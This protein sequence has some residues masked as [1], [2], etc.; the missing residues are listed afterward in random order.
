MGENPENEHGGPKSEVD[1][2]VMDRAWLE[3][4]GGMLGLRIN[5]IVG[6][7][8]ITANDMLPMHT[9]VLKNLKRLA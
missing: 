9:P 4:F 8:G 3:E 2:H 1:G 6:M 7:D 5:D